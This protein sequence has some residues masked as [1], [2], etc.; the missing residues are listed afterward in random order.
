MIPHMPDLEQRLRDA[1]RRYQRSADRTEELRRE[2]NALVRE[3]L[4]A[5]WTHA[6]IAELTGLSRGRV[7]QLR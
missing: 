2:R 6:R 7:N 3:A 1:E 4:A 5:G